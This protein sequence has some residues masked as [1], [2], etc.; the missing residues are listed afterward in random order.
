MLPYS[1]LGQ[2]FFRRASDAVTCVQRQ[3]MVIKDNSCS[4][5]GHASPITTVDDDGYK[6]WM[7]VNETNVWF[8]MAVHARLHGIYITFEC[9]FL[10]DEMG[11]PA[12]LRGNSGTIQLEFQ[13][14]WIKIPVRS[15]GIPRM[16][17]YHYR[18]SHACETDLSIN[19][20]QK[21]MHSSCNV[22]SLF[23]RKFLKLAVF[24]LT[25]ATCEISRIH[26][27]IR[28]MWN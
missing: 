20:F 1:L 28:H 13:H 23:F 11:K 8:W 21:P 7:M 17:I 9:K 4:S 25:F 14:V 15:N 12:R 26:A 6:A 19:A 10:H 3:R 27:D 22:I 18:L 16:Y 24:I 5:N 2:R